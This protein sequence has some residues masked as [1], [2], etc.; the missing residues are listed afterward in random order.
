MAGGVAALLYGRQVER[1]A[2]KGKTKGKEKVSVI[3]YI[4]PQNAGVVAK[5]R[6]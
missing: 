4:D 3:P 1:D 6:W 2:L 5:L